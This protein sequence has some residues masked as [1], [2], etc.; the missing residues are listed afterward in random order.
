MTLCCGSNCTAAAATVKNTAFPIRSGPSRLKQN[1]EKKTK[2]NMTGPVDKTSVS[3]DMSQSED[4]VSCVALTMAYL[5][6]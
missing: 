4:F 5:L 6:I 1:Y 2:Q 3:H